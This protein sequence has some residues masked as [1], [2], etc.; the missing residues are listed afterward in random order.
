MSYLWA[1]GW[2]ACDR[3]SGRRGI[4]PRRSSGCCLQR[5]AS[6]VKDAEGACERSDVLD[7][8]TGLAIQARASP[9]EPQFVWDARCKRRLSN[10]VL[11]KERRY[12]PSLWATWWRDP[13]P[14]R[15]IVGH[16]VHFSPPEAFEFVSHQPK[17]CT[18]LLEMPMR[19]GELRDDR[20]A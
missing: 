8:A 15:H 20:Q 10:L 12:L 2:H 9:N 5:E 14:E 19:L 3:G 11:D 16:L 6:R 7:L 1:Q 13:L 4:D 18:K 17:G